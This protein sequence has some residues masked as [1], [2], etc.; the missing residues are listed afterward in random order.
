MLL[1]SELKK[2]GITVVQEAAA[3]DPTVE[4][5]QAQLKQVFLNVILNAVQAMQG[6]GTI[7]V[8]M[9]D[10]PDGKREDSIDA[11]RVTICDTGPNVPVT[12]DCQSRDF[13]AD[14]DVDQDRPV[15]AR[16][17]CDSEDSEKS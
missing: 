2:Y 15:G 10:R 11:V 17:E 14:G 12:G 3:A 16:D 13:D 6:G 7:T 4:A 8:S 5:D 9:A 1:D